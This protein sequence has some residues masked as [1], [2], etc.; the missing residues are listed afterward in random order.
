MPPLPAARSFSRSKGAIGGVAITASAAPLLFFL[1]G[2]EERIAAQSAKW[3]P[4]WNRAFSH[5]TPRMERGVARVEPRVQRGVRV[6][7]PPL[8]GAAL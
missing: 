7:E 5:L 1:P 3:G 6:V 4:R 2:A 8:K